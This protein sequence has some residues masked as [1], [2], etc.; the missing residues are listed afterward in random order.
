MKQLRLIVMLSVALVLGTVPS[1]PAQ[2]RTDT[3]LTTE[4]SATLAKDIQ[5][6]LSRA[7]IKDLYLQTGTLKERPTSR[8]A[9]DRFGCSVSCGAG[10]AGGS[11]SISCN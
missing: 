10:L 1:V 11:C 8:S 9:N 4:Q 2:P 3:K 5:A 6:A 7:G